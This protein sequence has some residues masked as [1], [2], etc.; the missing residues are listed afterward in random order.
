MHDTLMYVKK[1]EAVGIPR[2]QAEAQVEI[3]SQIIDSNFATKQDLKDLATATKQDLKAEIGGL[4][5]EMRSEF[6]AVREEARIEF[7]AVREESRAEFA[8]VRLEIKDA[9]ITYGKMLAAAVGII[10]A[11]MGIMLKL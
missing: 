1:L 11:T 3:M 9:T 8:A 7:A 10:I 5:Q 2:D 4:R 6:T